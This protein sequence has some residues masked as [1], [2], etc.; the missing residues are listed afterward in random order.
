MPTVPLP[1]SSSSSSSSSVSSSSSSSLLLY[2]CETGLVCSLSF[3]TNSCALQEQGRLPRSNEQGASNRNGSRVGIV[4]TR[5]LLLSLPRRSE[6]RI[7]HVS[8][9]SFWEDRWLACLAVCRCHRREGWFLR[10]SPFVRLSPGASIHPSFITRQ[11][12]LAAACFLVLPVFS[13]FFFLLALH[14]SGSVCFRFVPRTLSH[15]NVHT[16]PSPSSLAIR[17]TLERVIHHSVGQPLLLLLIHN[18]LYN[19]STLFSFARDTNS[20]TRFAVWDGAAS[21]G[22]VQQS[23]GRQPIE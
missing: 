20:V 5:A 14:L 18:G 19:G 6:N 11:S 22:G 8:N 3:N 2:L 16:H 4:P 7:C 15:A 23:R 10:D 9:N 1:Q 21:V 12:S 13:P 17:G